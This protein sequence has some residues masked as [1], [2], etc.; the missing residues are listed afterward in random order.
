MRNRTSVA[1]VIGALGALLLLLSVPFALR[2]STS[3]SNATGPQRYTAIPGEEGAEN[4]DAF[5]AYWNDRV[6]YPTGRFNPGWVRKAAAQDAK[7][8]R[9]VPGGKK[10][11]QKGSAGD[12]GSIAGTTTAA[13]GANAGADVAAE[14]ANPSLNTTSF[15]ALGPKPLRM[16]GC[17]GCY[18]YGFTSGRIN[19]LVI[20]P[21]ATNVAYAASVGGGVW[22]TTTCCSNA[23]AWNVVTDDPLVNSTSIDTLALDPS[24]HDTICA[25][26]GDLNYGSFSMGSQGVLKSTNGGA[27]WTVLGTDVF[28]PA[29]AEPAG[30]FPQYDAVGKVRVDP[31]NS[32]NVVAGTKKGLFLSHDAGANWT[33]PCTT[34]SFTTQR[35][36]ITS[37]NLTNLGAGVTRIVAA[38]GT[39]GY[40]TSVQYDLGANGANGIYK[41]TMPASGCP[42]F[43]SIAG[44]GNGFVF[45][46]AVTGSPF[47]TGASLNAGSGAPYVNSTTG[48]Q[49]GRIDIGV[50]PSDPDTMYAQVQSI[51]QNSNSGCGN[52]NGCQ[53]GVFATTNG[54]TPAA[55]PTPTASRRARRR[56]TT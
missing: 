42:A 8:Q 18:D 24:N 20:D 53:L 54:G 46:T 15:V 14:G 34:N 50:A 49:V 22:K 21:V 31:N 47:T 10:R 36:D 17:S 5:E 56:A 55:A 6:T 7:I 48:N 19:D 9:R 1:S 40:A 25:G 2:H 3:A 43:T 28:G 11:G 44:N 13:G 30:Q 39:R 4:L 27:T 12:S 52:A 51:A 16:T 45:G 41:A 35:Q 29:Y 23:T 37:L 26:T 38:V 33:G 32:D